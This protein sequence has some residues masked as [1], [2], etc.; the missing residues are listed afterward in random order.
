[1]DVAVT[2]KLLASPPAAPPLV[3]D[4]SALHPLLCVGPEGQQVSGVLGSGW[5]SSGSSGSTG[6]ARRA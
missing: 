5:L 1:M 2:Y 4:P 3:L 6:A